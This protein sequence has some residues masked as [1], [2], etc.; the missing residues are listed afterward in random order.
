MGKVCTLYVLVLVFTVIH[1]TVTY[2][3]IYLF[4]RDL[5]G[6]LFAHMIVRGNAK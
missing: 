1:A 4:E 2:V 5:L 6:K 3:T